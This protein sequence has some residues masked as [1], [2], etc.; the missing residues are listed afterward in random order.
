MG[1]FKTKHKSSPFSGDVHQRTLHKNLE[2]T[3]TEQY[4]LMR[5]NL[6]FTIPEAVKV[7]RDQEV[8]LGV[9]RRI[10]LTIPMLSG[11]ELPVQSLSF[12]INPKNILQLP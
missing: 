8:K 5:T 3:A 6:N 1:L 7:D 2:F 4:K 10:L 9:E 11:F 12:I